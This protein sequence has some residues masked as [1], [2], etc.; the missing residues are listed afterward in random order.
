MKIREVKQTRPGLY[1]ILNFSKQGYLAWQHVSKDNVRGLHVCPKLKCII[2]LLASLSRSVPFRS[3]KSSVSLPLKF[4]SSPWV[5]PIKSWGTAVTASNRPDNSV[6]V[7]EIP[8]EKVD[9]IPFISDVLWMSTKLFKLE[10]ELVISSVIILPSRSTS[11]EPFSAIRI[12]K[13]V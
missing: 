9:S 1:R 5:S 8:L 6:T 11:K 3:M 12:C 10:V 4:P 2:L 7:M 13:F